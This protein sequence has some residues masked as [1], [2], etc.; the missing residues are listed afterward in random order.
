[1]SLD[2]IA[3]GLLGREADLLAYQR[4]S[5]LVNVSDQDHDGT[6]IGERRQ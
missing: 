4:L 6:I 2:L 5:S 3:G 1:M